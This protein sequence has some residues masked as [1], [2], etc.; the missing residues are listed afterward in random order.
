MNKYESY[1]I[2]NLD[3]LSYAGNLSN[4]HD[5]VDKKN[6]E[7]ILGDITDIEFIKKLFESHNF[8]SVIHLAAESHVDN[9]IKIL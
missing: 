6:Y 1:K 7:F 3:N 5:V 9:S 4:L 8:D 2:F